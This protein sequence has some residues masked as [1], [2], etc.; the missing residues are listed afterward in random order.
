MT[1]KQ[2]LEKLEGATPRDD[3]RSLVAWHAFV[4]R[5]G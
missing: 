4:T 2:R 5:S 3:G 1:L